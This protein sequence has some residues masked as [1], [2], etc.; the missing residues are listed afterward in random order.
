MPE[1]SPKTVALIPARGGS[2]RIPKKNLLQ[3]AGKPLLAWSVEAAVD[4]RV[5]DAVIIDSDDRK[6]ISIAEDYGA[7]SFYKRPKHLSNDDAPTWGVIKHLLENIPTVEIV[8]LLQPTSPLRTSHHI[9]EC[10]QK[11]HS[12]SLN[13]IV[14]VSKKDC[15]R[16]LVYFMSQHGHLS[17]VRCSP[18]DTKVYLNGA[19][20]L[21]K[22][23]W[24]L[25][26][27]KFVSC[28]TVG[29]IMP[30]KQSIDIDTYDDW[31]QALELK[32]D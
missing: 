18:R 12:S 13:S 21:F 17:K 9:I 25:D 20:Y 28:D 6:I 7:Q 2:K 1:N 5:F 10:M 24:F 32:H 22:T 16:D 8:M 26:C 4:S 3:F 27:N 23:K 31:Q 15:S 14:S 19:I 29:F 11:F 30:D